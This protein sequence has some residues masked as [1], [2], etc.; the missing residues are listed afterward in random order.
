M[1]EP[2]SESETD[3]RM[4]NALVEDAR[5]DVVLLVVVVEELITVLL[6]VVV[7]A[8][9][10]MVEGATQVEVDELLGGGGGGGDQVEVGAG[11]EGDGV[12]G[13][14]VGEGSCHVEVGGGGGGL[15]VGSGWGEPLS[16]HQFKLTTPALSSANR[17]NRPGERSK[18]P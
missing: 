18:S 2:L 7:G 4:A 17:R 13:A 5:A 14:G 15:V 1:L 6:E 16:N 9:D 11:G 8:A 10:D 3:E 12:Q